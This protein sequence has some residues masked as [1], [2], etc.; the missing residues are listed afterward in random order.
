MSLAYY[1]QYLDDLVPRI[2][3]FLESN[4]ELQRNFQLRNDPRFMNS[5][6]FLDDRLSNIVASITGR[7]ENFNSH[8]GDMWKNITAESF[9]KVRRLIT[10]HHLTVG[11]VLCGLTVKMRVWDNRFGRTPEGAAVV[12]RAEFIMGEMRQ[13]IDRI[14]EIEA[15][16][17]R[18]ADYN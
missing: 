11:G 14:E 13:G 15:S 10:A 18:I 8:T 4:K 12:S 3:S 16:A 1:K 6:A 7:F 2:S 9:R 5:C 17:P